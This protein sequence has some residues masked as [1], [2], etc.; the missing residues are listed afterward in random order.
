[1]ANRVLRGVPMPLLARTVTYL[2]NASLLA[3]RR[4]S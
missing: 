3:T 1:M 4:E 2:V